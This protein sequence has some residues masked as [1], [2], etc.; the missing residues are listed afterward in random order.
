MSRD[1]LFRFGPA[2]LGTIAGVIVVETL[3]DRLGLTTSSVVATVAISAILIF[4]LEEGCRYGAE[5][6]FRLPRFKQWFFGDRYI[7]GKWIDEV[8]VG[9]KPVGY[10]VITIADSG[11]EKV[12]YTGTNYDSHGNEIGIF[13]S[14]LAR[15]QGR[16]LIYMYA[17]PDGPEHEISNKGRGDV[18]FV[19][20]DTFSGSFYD[21][22]KRRWHIVH[23]KRLHDATEVAAAESGDALAVRALIAKHFVNSMGQDGAPVSTTAT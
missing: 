9:G 21:M 7:D 17:A 11:S 15:V 23:G 3:R 14:E 1:S 2:A 20:R 4:L 19:G 13:E 16:K 8:R 6:L 22:K 18:Q 5:G 10:G 12:T